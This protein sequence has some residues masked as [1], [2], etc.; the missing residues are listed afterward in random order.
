[1]NLEVGDEETR[2]GWTGLFRLLARLWLEEVDARLAQI[3]DDAP[4]GSGWNGSG[5][6]VSSGPIADQLEVLA[7]DFC[8]LFVGPRGHLVPVQ[9]VWQHA[10]LV[11]DPAASMRQWFGLAGYAPPAR[12]RSLFP[13][14][15]GIQLDLLAHLLDQ[16]ELWAQHPEEL[17]ALA[18][19]YADTHLAWPAPL[20]EAVTQRAQTPFYR[21]LAE[22]T[23]QALAALGES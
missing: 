5:D 21:R 22:L 6:W 12:H 17:A 19:T 14:H 3:L 2:R 15:L 13:D 8:Q 18:A 4:L 11:A 20:L 16:Q 10:A 7:V 23:N 1:M 9:S